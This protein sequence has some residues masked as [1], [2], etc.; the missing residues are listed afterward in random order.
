MN[1]SSVIRFDIMQTNPFPFVQ[2][3][4]VYDKER[5][6]LGHLSSWVATFRDKE[7]A[8]FFCN[9]MFRTQYGH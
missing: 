4:K 3:W 8:I 6:D 7:E 1:G 5:K 2:R 9:Q